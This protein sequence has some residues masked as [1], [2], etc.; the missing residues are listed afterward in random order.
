MERP[1]LSLPAKN[2]IWKQFCFDGRTVEQMIASADSR[3]WKVLSGGL[4][5]ITKAP[6]S[7]SMTPYFVGI[8]NVSEKPNEAK[9]LYTI[10]SVLQKAR[11]LKYSRPPALLALLYAADNDAAELGEKQLCF[12]HNPVY[13]HRQEKPDQQKRGFLFSLGFR[14]G[15]GSI[16]ITRADSNKKIIG[17]VDFAFC[18]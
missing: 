14:Q 3:G 7:V 9:N 5:L 15:Q 4:A 1:K 18:L 8:I 11:E 13:L 2:D 6:T 17:T 16:G 12:L 10:G